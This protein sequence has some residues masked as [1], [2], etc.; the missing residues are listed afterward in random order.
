MKVASSILDLSAA[1][2]N[3]SKDEARGQLQVWSGARSTANPVR[4]LPA[5]GARL[6]MGEDRLSLSGNRP[7]QFSPTHQSTK[8]AKASHVQKSSEA[9]TADHK[10][11][12]LKRIVEAMTGKEI[13]LTDV[14]EF[15]GEIEAASM[16]GSQDIIQAYQ[17]NSGMTYIQTTSHYE[18]QE[19]QFSV[20]GSI[21]TADGQEIE[22]SLSL[23]MT[24]EIYQ[25]DSLTLLTGNGPATD[26]LVLNFEG[27]AA[28]LSNMTFAFDLDVDGSKEQVPFFRSG[29]GFLVFDRN[30]DGIINDGRELFGPSTGDGF[31]ELAQFDDDGNLWIDENDPI[32]HRLAVWTKDESGTDK[33]E[34]LEEKGV[35]A[36]SL[37]NI[38]TPF[39]L[40]DAANEL[41]GQV[42]TTG[43]YLGESGS[44]NTIQ[45]IDLVG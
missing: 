37:T 9:P 42:R 6:S 29:R 39:D 31:K 17:A 15:Q 32:F 24:R 11:L 3:V 19:T 27:K 8:H 10:L 14:R 23:K 35:G 13:H 25:E 34:S 22:F 12:M 28:E 38:E 36:I 4:S 33:L 7:K 1:H 20:S 2:T 40:K 26:P 21:M 41:Q 30:Q 5:T 43:I 16:E 44:V 45:Q 18:Y